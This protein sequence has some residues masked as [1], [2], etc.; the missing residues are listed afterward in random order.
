M[1]AGQH[2]FD[3]VFGLGHATHSDDRNLH[4]LCHLIDHAQHYRFQ[5]RRHHSAE[6][7]AQRRPEVVG[8]DFQRQERIGDH[9]CVSAG[10]FRCQC[11]GR[12]IPGIGRQL[13]PDRL[14]RRPTNCAHY[15]LGVLFL[16]GEVTAGRVPGR[17]RNIAFD[18]IDIRHRK[19]VR[20]RS[21][22]ID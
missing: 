3:H 20:Q 9:Q 12:Q 1:G 4:F 22:I 11:D 6:F 15:F 2:V 13:G 14:V 8:T 16:Q 10:F 17:A 5:R 18:Y 21:E 19:F 7:I